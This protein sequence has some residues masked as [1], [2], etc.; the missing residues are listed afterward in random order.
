ML[1]VFPP[2]GNGRRFMGRTVVLS[3]SAAA[4]LVVAACTS[5][6][7]PSSAPGGSATSVPNSASAPATD[8]STANTTTSESGTAEPSDS[9]GS[10]VVVD[11]ET[12]ATDSK[13][14]C[15]QSLNP[16]SANEFDIQLKGAF[17][18][19][20]EDYQ[21][22]LGVMINGEAPKG[23]EWNS[24]RDGPATVTKTADGFT[25]TGNATPQENMMYKTPSGSGPPAPFE[26]DVVS[27]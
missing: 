19:L 23:W 2:T 14:S 17:I 3:V 9:G 18:S 22:V 24:D 1:H 26:I 13:A 21:R 16:N 12:I 7:K 5:G 11:G 6:E 8:T 27:S 20:T 25:I 10:K 4:I 15:E